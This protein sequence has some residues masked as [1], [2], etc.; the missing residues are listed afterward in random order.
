MK[1]IIM[2]N[3]SYLD[4]DIH[5]SNVVVIVAHFSMVGNT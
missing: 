4:L 1:L 3:V 2:A 5:R